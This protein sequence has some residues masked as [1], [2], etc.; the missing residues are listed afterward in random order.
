MPAER[1]R[2]PLPSVGPRNNHDLL[3]PQMRRHS[4]I[5]HRPPIFFSRRNRA[6]NTALVRKIEF[7]TLACDYRIGDFYPH[8]RP[9]AATDV[10]PVR[11]GRERTFRGNGQYGAR[12]VVRTGNDHLDVVQM[13]RLDH[14]GKQRTEIG[15]RM[16]WFAEELFRDFECRQDI[17]RPSSRSRVQHLCSR[18][19]GEFIGLFARQKPVE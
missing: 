14:A 11:T 15:A 8:Q 7:S 3:P 16:G 1:L 2:W 18:R 6:A 5:N 9:G 13:R 10:A 12:R 19:I 17:C 4:W